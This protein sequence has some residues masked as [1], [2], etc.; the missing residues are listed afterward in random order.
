M[1]NEKKTVNILCYCYICCNLNFKYVMFSVHQ[2]LSFDRSLVCSLIHSFIDGFYIDYLS[3]YTRMPVYMLP[4]N[5]FIRSFNR[6]KFVEFL[7][8]RRRWWWWRWFFCSLKFRSFGSFEKNIFFFPKRWIDIRFVLFSVLYVSSIFLNCAFNDL[9]FFDQYAYQTTYLF[10]CSLFIC[11][12]YAKIVGMTP[13]ML[14][15]RTVSEKKTQI[16]IHIYM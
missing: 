12:E 15:I 9:D 11:Q 1:Q 13:K 6:V 3:I 2:H 14:R 5:V 7:F 4:S 10:F 16:F 8:R